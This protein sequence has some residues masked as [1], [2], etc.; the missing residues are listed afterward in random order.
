MAVTAATVKELRERSGAGMME[1]KK[2]LVAV[3]GDMDAAIEHLR[4]AGLAQADKKAGRIAAEGKIM[5]AQNDDSAVLVEVNSETDFVAKDGNFT[6][7][8][9][10]V[11]EQALGSD[12]DDPEALLGQPHPD[13]GSF[14]EARQALVSKVG[15][16]IQVR[17][18]E[19]MTSADGGLIG[20]Y[21][22]GGR[23]GVLVRVSGASQEVARDVAMHV[24]AMNPG[25]LDADSVPADVLDK[26]R[27]I[28]KAQAKDSGKP[29]E[30]ID[31]MVEG[32][33][34]KYFAETTLLGQPFVKDSDVSVGKFL[35]NAGAQVH[36]FARI[37][38]GE[39]IE[40]GPDDFAAEVRA[41]AGGS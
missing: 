16:N 8:A 20:A 36:E 2:A 21:I 35:G 22:H 27:E 28:L 24:A 39:G 37:E 25:Y 13:G 4:K 23:I 30:I 5:L 40:K 38:V 32:R 41:Q 14:E 31:K 7:F 10:A 6:G 9:Q 18:I 33:L 11:A 26:E 12:T 34:R 3:D 1:C 29:P 17:R 15:E 19:R